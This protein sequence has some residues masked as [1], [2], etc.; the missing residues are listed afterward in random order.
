MGTRIPVPQLVPAEAGRAAMFEYLIGNLDWS[1]SAG[2]PGDSCCHN[3]KL[4][5]APGGTYLPV[6]YDFD[7]SG[8]VDAPYATP[9]EVVKVSSVRE[10]RYRGFCRHNAQALAAA[11]ELRAE[12]PALLALLAQIPQLDERSR[13]KASAYL[14]RGFADIASDASVRDKLFRTCVG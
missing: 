9:P 8:M 11:A 5:A 10:R 1:M 7:F 3:F 14:E 12:R 6:P 13:R 4:F 2:P